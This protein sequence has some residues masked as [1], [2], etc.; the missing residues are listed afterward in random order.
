MKFDYVPP[1]VCDLGRSNTAA[2]EDYTQAF[3]CHAS[4]YVMGDK[5]DVEP[6][7]KLALYKLFV[8]L[9]SFTLYREGVGDIVELAQYAYDHT[10]DSEDEELRML[11]THYMAGKLETFSQDSRFHAILREPG[12]LA[13]DLVCI[14]SQ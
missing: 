7:R 6:L 9:H 14:L 1:S 12:S 4:L 2:N 13:K 8:T 5:Y 11:V 3:L 10:R